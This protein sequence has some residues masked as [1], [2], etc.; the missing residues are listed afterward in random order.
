MS[1]LLLPLEIAFG[2]LVVLP[3]FG[4]LL[5]AVAADDWLNGRRA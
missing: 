4:L 3:L 5:L 2:L 1:R